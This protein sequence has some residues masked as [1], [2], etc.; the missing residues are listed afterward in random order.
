[1]YLHETN[2]IN[3]KMAFSFNKLKL[4]VYIFLDYQ[5]SSRILIEILDIIGLTKQDLEK[6]QL[7]MPGYMLVP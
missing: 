3:I 6:N 5:G 1:M 4:T 7:Q 2:T